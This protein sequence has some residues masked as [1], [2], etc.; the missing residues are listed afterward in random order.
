MTHKPQFI[1]LGTLWLA[2]AGACGESTPVGPSQTPPPLPPPPPSPTTVVVTGFVRTM[3]GRLCEGCAVEVMDGASTGTS[4]LTDS[5]GRFSLSISFSGNS[6]VTLEASKT[7]YQPATRSTSGGPVGF[8]L[9]SLHPLDLAGTYGMNFEAG[10]ECAE[11]PESIRKRQYIVT[12]SRH[13]ERPQSVF[14]ARPVE[15][16]FDAFQVTWP[17]SDKEAAVLAASGDAG[18]IPGIV[19]RFASDETVQLAVFSGP[20]EIIAAAPMRIPVVG[21]VSYCKGTAGC[22]SC[23][24]SGHLLTMTRRR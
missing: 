14:V 2:L 16:S 18:E 13:P 6:R 22:T 7:G 15:G 20:V 11:L 19:E 9:E 10:A 17:V 4:V 5:N 12:L 3:P 8:E 23:R 21:L 24:S 1:A